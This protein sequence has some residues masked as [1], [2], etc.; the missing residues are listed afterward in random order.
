M[1][2]WYVHHHG[3]GHLR[4]LQAIRPHLRHHDVTVLSSLRRPDDWQGDWVH[5]PM[6]LGA[7][8]DPTA[9]GALHWAPTG[10]PGYRERMRLIAAWVAQ[11]DPALFMVDVSVEVTALV[12]LLGVRTATVVMPGDRS[13]RPHRTGYDLADLLIGP[14]PAG[15]HR[16][17]AGPAERV[18]AVGAIS[19]FDG[20]RRPP[21]EPVPGRVLVLNGLGDGPSLAD[22]DKIRQRVGG[23]WIVRGGRGERS[24]DL[25]ADLTSA[26]VV[27]THA[28]QNAV[29][30]VAAAR[31]P[32]VVVAAER[33]HEEQVATVRAL[34]RAGLGVPLE[35]W[36]DLDRWPDL[37]KQAR[38][39]GAEGWDRWNPG[40]GAQRAADAIE[41]AAR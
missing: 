33:P 9:H 30:D 3:G 20:G 23:E 25:W 21:L 39:R 19:M 14:W 26:E 7:D 34:R 27:V 4:R 16:L 17:P 2:G 38:R 37:L 28:G 40:N 10:V 12:R 29:A 8:A 35:S 31:R 32:A 11:H 18:V 24:T 13:D 36:P 5:L 1:I 41:D 6:D 15:A 22:I